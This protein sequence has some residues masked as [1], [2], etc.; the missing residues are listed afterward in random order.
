MNV[1][2]I[3][4]E[5]LENATKTFVSIESAAQISR[6][7]VRQKLEEIFNLKENDLYKRKKEINDIVNRV[8]TNLLEEENK[9]RNEELKIKKEQEN[10]DNVNDHEDKPT[11]D[12][13]TNKNKMITKEENTKNKNVKKDNNS[14]DQ[15]MCSQ[16]DAVDKNSSKKR[17]STGNDVVSV[18]K[19]QANIMTKDYFLKHA[20]SILCNMSENINLTLEPRIFSTGSCGWHIMDKIYL[21]VGDRNV[22]CQFCINCS[23]IGS[24][25]W[26]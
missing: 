2:D 26:D 13:D 14:D 6:R 7:H 23:V 18:R 25:Q 20:K 19:K 24:K 22:L 11:A 5:Q 8:L 3:T 4:T 10:N 1:E 15:T 17:K 12:V 9:K 21:L 16:T